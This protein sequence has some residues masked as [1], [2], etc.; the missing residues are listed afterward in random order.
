MVSQRAAGQ[1]R[2]EFWVPG[3]LKQDG[4]ARAAADGRSLSEVLREFLREYASAGVTAPPGR[5]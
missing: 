5:P 3:K 1:V 2:V 4:T